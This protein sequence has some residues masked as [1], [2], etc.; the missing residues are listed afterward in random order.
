MLGVKATAIMPAYAHS[1]L[2][3]AL[4]DRPLTVRNKPHSHVV[5]VQ[6]SH[7]LGLTEKRE[8]NEG[9]VVEE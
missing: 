5:L 8:V 9:E 4:A 7:E 2:T 3:L 1:C 6:Y